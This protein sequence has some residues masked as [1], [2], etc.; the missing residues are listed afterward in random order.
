MPVNMGTA[1]CWN[2]LAA[3]HPAWFLLLI[4]L[5]EINYLA[6]GTLPLREQPRDHAAGLAAASPQKVHWKTSLN[7][8]EG[9]GE[10][11]GQRVTSRASLLFKL[12]HQCPQLLLPIPPQSLMLLGMQHNIRWENPNELQSWSTYMQWI[13]L[14]H[15]EPSTLQCCSQEDDC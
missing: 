11:E 1:A 12:L 9:F 7:W 6:T 4:L 14:L 8:E 13:Q 5:I 3:P 10:G 2:K 15:S